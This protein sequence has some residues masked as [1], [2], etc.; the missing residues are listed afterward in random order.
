MSKQAASTDER[1][2]VRDGRSKTPVTRH[3]AVLFADL[4]G[5]SALMSRDEI[6]TLEFMVACSDLV[7][8]LGARFG[9]RVVQTTGDGYLVLFERVL[10]AVQFGMQLHRIV[11]KRQEGKSTRARFRVGI[12]LGEVHD[13]NGAIYGHAVNVAARIQAEALPGTC[14]LS[15]LA[16]DEVRQEGD[17]PFES[18]G[19]PPL[20]N[21]VEQ[22]SLYR[23]PE[24]GA[25]SRPVEVDIPLV[26]VVGKLALRSPGSE[27]IFPAN[28]KH[29]GLF[30]YL[31]LSEGIRQRHEKIASLLWP[32][33]PKASTRTL[34]DSRRK[35]VQMLSGEIEA[36]LVS[37][38][39]YIGLNELHFD[40]DLGVAER[41]IRRGRVPDLLIRTPDWPG[42]IL[43]GFDELS[44]VFSGWLQVIRASWRAR[45]LTALSEL[46]GKSAPEDDRC[47]DAAQA[48]IGIDPGNEAAAAALIRFFALN[49]NRAA[50]LREYFRLE[51]HLRTRYSLAPG[52]DVNEALR[53]AREGSVPETVPRKPPSP[54]VQSSARLLRI[55]VSAFSGT[56]PV[57]DPVDDHVISG[58]RNE[59][60]ANL[61]RFR[62]WSVVDTEELGANAD[63]EPAHG[64]YAISGT[65]L[66]TPVGPQLR[67]KLRDSG[68]RVVWSDE[69]TVSLSDWATLQLTIVGRI[70]G[71]LETYISADRLHRVIRSG[72]RDVLSHDEWLRAEQIFSR[73][74]PEAIDEAE[75]ILL[76]IIDRDDAFAPAYSSLASFRNVQHV[77]RPGLARDA[78]GARQAHS[79]A[80]R[81]VE[82]DPLDARNHL[83]VAWTAAMT[84]A[85]DRAAIH[86][87]LASRLNPNSASTL[88]SCAMGY[89]FVGHADRAQTLVAHVLR[90]SP[91]L[92]DDQWCY[93]A[94]VHFLAGRHDEALKAARLSG[95]RIV[96]NPG[97]AAAA[98][99]RMD[100]I[101]EARAEFERLIDAVRPIWAG[102]GAPTAEAVFDWF[103]A[104]YPLRRDADSIALREALGAAMRGQ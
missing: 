43:D 9:G 10:D 15:E 66:A 74:T 94:A 1:F 85:F 46:L 79:Y 33:D 6:G 67:V 53:L 17:F 29:S 4:V 54:V 83:A 98:L 34:A 27:M 35:L 45:M 16:H 91:M 65:Y 23:I 73:W 32:G 81:A 88:V 30:G 25:A 52:A 47:H 75:T 86:F 51:S 101:D 20:K 55:D 92:R 63:P 39:G 12:H 70:A 42:L 57:D 41:E 77:V 60:L 28:K 36:L 49:G 69:F 18:I 61:A 50:A 76:R 26:T 22:I 78:A 31:V 11:S 40:T 56:C 13:V 71:H 95:D 8:E 38:D 96:D 84:D 44:P 100:R 48:I 37:G 2:D 99:V 5:Y 102:P 24:E 14:V 103:T 82:I 62:E 68:N 87:D 64:H 89:A 58:F 19:R 7:E 72:G 80:E 93:L 3:F 59:L 21:I 90:I 97:W 104:A